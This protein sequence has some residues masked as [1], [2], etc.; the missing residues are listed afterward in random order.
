M[1]E[2]AEQIC[3]SCGA[4]RAR[5]GTANLEGGRNGVEVTVRGVPAFLCDSCG[6]AM[7]PGPLAGEIWGAIE[8]IIQSVERYRSQ[9]A[10]ASEQGEPS[11]SR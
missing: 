7:F 8:S 2:Q 9:V 11:V 5:P 4:T 10:T 3:T 1:G 6:E